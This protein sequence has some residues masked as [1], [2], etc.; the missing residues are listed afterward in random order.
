MAAQTALS[1]QVIARRLDVARNGLSPE[2]GS[3]VIEDVGHFYQLEKP[4]GFNSA[5]EE[6]ITG[7][8][9]R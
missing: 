1:M 2:T 5:V 4:I 3:S 9:F 7:L 8:N 6:F